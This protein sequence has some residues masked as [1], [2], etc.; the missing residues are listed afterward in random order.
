MRTYRDGKLSLT[1]GSD[2]VTGVGTAFLANIG[3]GDIVICE[4]GYSF[5]VADVGDDTTLRVD[6]PAKSTILTDYAAMRFVTSFNF[7]DLALKIE[8]FLEDREVNLQEFLDWQSGTVTGGP[9]GDG[10]Y[11][12]TDRFGIVHLVPCPNLIA[13]GYG[14]A[15]AQAAA[16]AASAIAAADSATL[17]SAKAADIDG[18]IAEAAASAAESNDAKNLAGVKATESAN[19]AASSANSAINSAASAATSESNAASAASTLAVIV[20]ESEDLHELVADVTTVVNEAKAVAIAKAAESATAATNAAASAST[21]VSSA[22]AAAST[23]AVIVEESEDLHAYV[24]AQHRKLTVYAFEKAVTV[25]DK[26]LRIAPQFNLSSQF[27]TIDWVGSCDS[28]GSCTLEFRIVNDGVLISTPA[29][30]VF[31]N[32]VAA[33]TIN[34]HF[35]YNGDTLEIVCT[36]GSATNLA[37]TARYDS[38][39]A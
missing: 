1:A 25:G 32:K 36:A 20:E 7:R 21:S 19:S 31:T 24:A 37:L 27:S 3:I 23:L 14:G 35:I 10:L 15:T 9:G 22:A 11:P 5:E 29:T 18:K 17:A 39:A 4:N 13:T 6:T 12:M 8:Q 33:F 26:I 16:A 30:V 2:I 34:S 38:E 28:T